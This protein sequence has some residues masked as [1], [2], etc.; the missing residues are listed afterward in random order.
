VESDDSTPTLLTPREGGLALAEFLDLGF[1][2][3]DLQS[4]DDDTR[5]SDRRLA[6][7]EPLEWRSMLSRIET[8]GAPGVSSRLDARP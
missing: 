2:G 3:A 6:D 8:G 1:L 5:R 4:L 7:T